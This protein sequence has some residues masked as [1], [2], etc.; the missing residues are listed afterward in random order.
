MND[1]SEH[2]KQQKAAYYQANKHLWKAYQNSDRYR[3][4]ARGYNKKVRLAAI[5][6]YGGKCECC[7]E[8][9]FEFMAIDHINGGGIQHRKQLG[10]SGN[11]IAKWLKKNDYPEGFRILCHNCNLALG[12]YKQCPHKKGK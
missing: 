9:R 11:S 4:L 5:A 6:A 3:E 7:G 12:F 10:W 1:K 2:R 8:D